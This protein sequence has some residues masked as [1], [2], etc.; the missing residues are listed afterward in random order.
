MSGRVVISSVRR[1]EIRDGSPRSTEEDRQITGGLPE[2][3]D[4]NEQPYNDHGL[5][6]GAAMVLVIPLED[7]TLEDAHRF[8]VAVMRAALSTNPTLRRMFDDLHN[9]R[10]ETLT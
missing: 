9:I 4:N 5:K 3:A 8:K 2:G 7:V 10:Q 1:E 6:A